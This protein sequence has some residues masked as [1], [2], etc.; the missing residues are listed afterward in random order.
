MLAGSLAYATRSDT[1]H[2]FEC[3]LLYPDQGRGERRLLS[4]VSRWPGIPESSCLTFAGKLE[5][6]EWAEM[7]R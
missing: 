3:R 7:S 2:C 5:L 4:L 6:I 1:L